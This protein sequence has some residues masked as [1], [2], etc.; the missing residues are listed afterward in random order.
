MNSINSIS[1]IMHFLNRTNYAMRFT[2]SKQ[3]CMYKVVM[4][5]K[6]NWDFSVLEKNSM[7]WI[8]FSK[9]VWD[10]IKM[11]LCEP[12]FH[13]LLAHLSII[14]PANRSLYN[15]RSPLPRLSS[16]KLAKKIFQP[17]KI[18]LFNNNYNNWLNRWIS[19]VYLLNRASQIG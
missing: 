12:K 19:R 2:H 9:M 17:K 16:G 8:K 11:W 3:N 7:N 6:M 4:R 18:I 15:S 1:W 13:P 10:C 14:R 5:V